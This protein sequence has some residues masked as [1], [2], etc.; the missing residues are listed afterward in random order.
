MVKLDGVT[1]LIREF[2]SIRYLGGPEGRSSR[3]KIMERNRLR[4]GYD[5]LK[6]KLTKKIAE[7]ARQLF[8]VDN[9]TRRRFVQ[10]ST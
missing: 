6:K 9:P 8:C 7:D 3:G 1:R 5:R 10:E 4:G 2:S